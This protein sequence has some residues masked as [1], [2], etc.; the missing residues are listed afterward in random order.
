M[1]LLNY[2]SNCII[3]CCTRYTRCMPWKMA[4]HVH[5]K[6]TRMFIGALLIIASNWELPKYPLTIKCIKKK[7]KWINSGTLNRRSQMQEYV[8]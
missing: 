1:Q 4:A 6:V 5:Q 8:L 7:N 3:N 2:I